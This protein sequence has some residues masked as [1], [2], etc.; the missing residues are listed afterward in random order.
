[1][2]FRVFW[3]ILP[4]S[5]IDVDVNWNARNP[6]IP[7]YMLERQPYSDLPTFIPR[8]T[9]W[10]STMNSLFCLSLSLFSSAFAEKCWDNLK[11]CHYQCLSVHHSRYP[12]L[13]YTTLPHQMI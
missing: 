10:T 3:D 13:F 5:Q 1:M 12:I 6:G 8:W 9:A 4:C 11:I 7:Q 2:K